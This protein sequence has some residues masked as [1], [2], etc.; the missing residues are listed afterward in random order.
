MSKPLRVALCGLLV[1]ALASP[2]FADGGLVKR[3]HR[4]WTSS[5]CSGVN[6]VADQT[7]GAFTGCFK[8]TFSLFNPCLDA[9]KGCTNVVMWP[10]EKPFDYMER[11]MVSCWPC[12]KTVKAPAAKKP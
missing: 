2:V 11:T 5:V 6:K 10:I 9:I 7:A 4:S 12:S 8:R 1:L 3:H